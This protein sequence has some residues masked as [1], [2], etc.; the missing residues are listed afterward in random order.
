MTPRLEL[1]AAVVLAQLIKS[2]K[3]AICNSFGIEQWFC[4]SDSNVVLYWIH[5]EH[6]KQTCFIETR[7]TQIRNLVAKQHWGYCPSQNNPADILSRGIPLSKMK[8]NRLWWEGSMFLRSEKDWPI[9]EAAN[10]TPN[11]IDSDDST[12]SLVSANVHTPDIN[13]LLSCENYSCFDNLIRITSLVLKYVK[14]LFR[15]I[16]KETHKELLFSDLYDEATSLWYKG[17]Q[18]SFC[19]DKQFPATNRILEYFRTQQEFY[20]LKRELILTV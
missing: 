10:K 20:A 18:K 9:F 12:P 4:W 7:L 16:S 19:D 13:A 3:N 1:K 14:L 8:E 11:F 2:I 5:N 15:K 6:K 17:A